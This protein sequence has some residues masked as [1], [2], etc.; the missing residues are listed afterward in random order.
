[1]VAYIELGT[2]LLALIVL[3]LLVVFIRDPIA[4][5]INSLI[6]IGI[7]FI[8]NAL[9]GLGIPINIFTVLIVTLGGLLGLVILLLLRLL[10]VAFVTK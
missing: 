4:I 2:L 5:L 1:M 6:A 9:F 7:L 3:L 8:L 10:K